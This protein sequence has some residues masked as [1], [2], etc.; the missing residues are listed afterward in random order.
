MSV[1]KLA[2]Y[3]KGTNTLGLFYPA[4]Q[5]GEQV[6][7]DLVGF[8]DAAYADC[9]VSRKSTSGYLFCVNGSPV[10]WQ[11]GRQSVV[12]TSSTKAEYIA[13]FEGTKEAVWLRGL[14]DDMGFKP[15]HPTV[16]F[17]D[18]RLKTPSIIKGLSM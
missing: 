2:R 18:N 3:L 12:T 4:R 11:S 7:M 14:F 10:T 9:L 8:V 17:E 15:V 6:K 16:L 5:Q 13:A 1:M